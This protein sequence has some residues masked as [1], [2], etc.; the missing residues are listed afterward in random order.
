MVGSA[1]AGALTAV[2][3]I[4]CPAP[5]GGIFTFIVCNK[6]LLYI[7]ALVVGSIAGALMLA[8]LKKN[9]KNA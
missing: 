3:G 1:V 9:R 6:P 8:L 5:H 4:T 2:F 7:V